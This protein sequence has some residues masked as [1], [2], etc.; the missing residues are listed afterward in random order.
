MRFTTASALVSCV[1]QLPGMI[2]HVN[3]GD[4]DELMGG[5]A[6]R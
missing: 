2:R 4:H 1:G 6:P 3:R 5:A